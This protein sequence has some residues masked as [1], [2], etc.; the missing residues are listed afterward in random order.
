[1]LRL[2]MNGFD[3]SFGLVF[4]F[5]GGSISLVAVAKGLIYSADECVQ[6]QS[7]AKERASR[8]S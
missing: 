3:T 7:K 4:L 5:F 6:S 1:M 2:L 8:G